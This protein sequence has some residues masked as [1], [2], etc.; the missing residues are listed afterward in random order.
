MITKLPGHLDVTFNRR[1]R[2]R[3]PTQMPSTVHG[4]PERIKAVIFDLDDTLVVSTV[5]YRKFKKLVIER[6]A[7]YGNDASLY[8]PAETIVKI[9]ARY[10]SLM[11]KQ[12]LDSEVNRSR[13][14]EL[15]RIMDSVELE[16]VGD[17]R[18]IDGAARLL[19]MLRSKGIK[20]GLLTRGCHEYASS[21]LRSAGLEMLVDAIEC[22]NSES[23]AK[24][25]PEAYLRVASR[26]GIPSD[27]T[28]FVGDHPIDAQCAK[29]AG[30]GF[31]A[32]ETGDVPREALEAAGCV[33]V[34]KDVG[35][36]VA[37]FERFLSD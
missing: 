18:A 25:D 6:I 37:W 29:N 5:D 2:I 24:P 27:K 14:S 30:V 33:A 8:S 19:K 21:A 36:L 12:G 35:H 22:R 26:L 13:L 9:L 28:L 4:V 32:V 31:I 17:T 15:D 34:F 11:K 3:E 10:E 20:I 23:K 7:S 16:H 1:E